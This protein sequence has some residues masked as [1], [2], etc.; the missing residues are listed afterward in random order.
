MLKRL[1]IPIIFICAA[2][3]LHAQC[4]MLGFSTYIGPCNNGVYLVS[5]NLSF[6]NAPVSGQLII[7][8]SSGQSLTFYA[9]FGSQMNYEF[10]NIPAT[11]A[12]TTLS[13]YFTANTACSISITIVNTPVCPC[14]I[15][16]IT[17]N[18]SACESQG[19]TFNIT[20]QIAFV[21]PPNIGTLT[22]TDCS[23][24]T[25]IFE[26]PFVSPLNYALNGIFANATPNCMVTAT[27][28][29]APNCSIESDVFNYPQLCNCDADVGSF[30]VAPLG[31]SNSI[32]NLCPGDQILF[33]ANN[34]F[35]PP[36]NIGGTFPYDPNLGLLAF[37]CPPTTPLYGNINNDPCLVG[38]INGQNNN[39]WAVSNVL[40]DGSMLYLVPVTLYNAN[41]GLI[42]NPEFVSNCYDMGEVYPIRFLT[43][44]NGNVSSN[45]QTGTLS[46]NISG[47]YPA[48]NGG[49]FTAQN[50]LPSSASFVNTTC[51]N[52]GNINVSG[53][54]DGD[55]YSFDVLAPNGCFI[56]ISGVFEGL[57][58]LEISYSENSFCSD[59]VNPIPQIIG[60]QGG[61]F[62]S[63]NSGLVINPSTGEI[64]LQNSAAGTY[65]VIYQS[66]EP[67]CF[68]I[69]N[70]ELSIHQPQVVYQN[71]SVCE[72][73]VPVVFSGFTFFESGEEAILFTDSFGCDSTVI[74]SV[75]VVP[76]PIP[77]IFSTITEGC[78]PLTVNFLNLTEGQYSSC[79]WDFGVNNG[80][81][82]QCG[83]LNHTFTNEGCFDISL[84][85]TNALGCTG[86][87]T[88]ENY[89][90]AIATPEVNF[91]TAS[92][93]I[94]A[95]DPIVQ[96]INL[97]AFADS[98]FWNF[99]DFN[100]STDFSPTHLYPEEAGIYSVILYSFNDYCVDSLTQIIEVTNKP[101][102][103]V[104]NSFTPNN[105]GV[106]DLF[107]P[108]IYSGFDDRFYSFT[109]FNRW[110]ELL[111]ETQNYLQGWDGIFDGISV[112]DGLYQYTISF[113][114]AE[115]E[116]ITLVR[117][118]VLVIR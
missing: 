88:L 76:T 112:S 71:Y 55:N 44:I 116:D 86:I 92:L 46:A 27:F 19:N 97:S 101:I 54:Q 64:N 104:P 102:Y 107:L 47:G 43:E 105:D 52:N 99:G 115:N 87:V 30:T 98:N 51:G 75:E 85:V 91:T 39:S 14:I 48:A 9:P 34:N 93:E 114:H 62:S 2:F 60:Q 103:Y 77:V 25:Q 31:Q 111:F 83:N 69:A 20:G 72:V 73:D 56:T 38:F 18:V 110:G 35:I 26:P 108:I 1:L 96:F 33:S 61:T 78:T 74:I 117:G 49:N 82:N 3:T 42:F 10:D 63:Q 7:T 79:V 81:V 45:C 65:T 70:F 22:I 59:G 66:P 29:G 90:C 58:P 15:T 5:G 106:N 118:H 16:G 28:T 4:T 13:A 68:S 80:I 95:N 32:S 94:M 23:G 67:V 100:F 109:I 6:V 36:A 84:A 89:I 57:L 50:L 12:P 8:S 37:S 41:T 21:T 53:L 40:A 11:G 17:A 113:K 24:N